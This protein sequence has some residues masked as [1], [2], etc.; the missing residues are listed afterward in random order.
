MFNIVSHTHTRA[1]MRAR[2]AVFPQREAWQKKKKL[3]EA[4]RYS[5]FK[6]ELLSRKCDKR[7]RMRFLHKTC[8]HSLFWCAV[9]F[10]LHQAC[11]CWTGYTMGGT[12]WHFKSKPHDNIVNVTRSYNCIPALLFLACLCLPPVL[13]D[14]VTLFRVK[15][16]AVPFS[17]ISPCQESRI[18]LRRI[19][20]PPLFCSVLFLPPCHCHNYRIDW[21]DFYPTTVP[22]LALSYW[23]TK[24]FIPP[25]FHSALFLPA[26][27]MSSWLQ[28]IFFFLS[29]RCSI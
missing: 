23:L 26:I 4:I 15:Q 2:V 17:V 20:I 27:V 6:H 3:R 9:F 12:A 25:L 22:P 21:Q 13:V 11:S 8:M 5:K 1:G 29:R 10:G 7:T 18:D 16:L 14:W 24:D 19:F 28:G